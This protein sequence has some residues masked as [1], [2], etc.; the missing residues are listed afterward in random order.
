M[1]T[2]NEFSGSVNG[3]GILVGPNGSQVNIFNSPHGTVA[4]GRLAKT[5][6]DLARNVRRRWQGEE[7]QRGISDPDPLPVQWTTAPGHPSDLLSGSR[8]VPSETDL[9][10]RLDR[11]AKVVRRIGA[12]RRTDAGRLVVLGQAGSGKTILAMQLALRLLD[13]REPADPVPVIFSLGSWDPSAPSLRDWLTSQLERD[14][15]ALAEALASG[16]T[17]ACGL[18]SDRWILPVLD[19][20]DEIACGLRGR[21]LKAVSAIQI[22][23]VLTSRPDEYDAATEG[24]GLSKAVTVQ[25]A[26]LTV[27]ELREY[28]PQTTSR[29]VRRPDGTAVN[30]WDFILGD[31]ARDPCRHACASLAEV[32]RT[33]LMVTLARTVYS[34]ASGPDPEGLLDGRYGSAVELEEHL[35][36]SFISSIYPDEPDDGPGG[37]RWPWHRHWSADRA[38]RWLGYLAA[39]MQQRDTRDLAWWELGTSMGRLPRTLWIAFLA[40]LAFGLATAM[41]NLPVDLVATS[42]G[43]AF[44]IARGIAVGALHGLVVG[45]A[46]GLLYWF[47]QRGEVLKPSPVRIRIFSGGPGR[48]Q[49]RPAGRVKIGIVVGLPVALLIALIDRYLVTWLG[50][51]DGLGGGPLSSLL[52]FVPEAGLAAG[53]VFALISLIE[54]PIDIG[55]AVSPSVLLRSSRA[56]AIFYLLGWALVL[57]PEFGLVTGVTHGALRGLEVGLVYGLEGAFGAGLGYGMVMCAWGQWVALARIWLPLTGRLPWAVVAFLEDACRRGALR[58]AGAVYQFRHARLQDYLAP[59]LRGEPAVAGARPLPYG[60]QQEEIGLLEES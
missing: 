60:H 30:M 47:A 52:G 46:F 49:A 15:P 34:E 53:L 45:L 26:D 16:E 40:A 23:L 31:L 32:L 24:R 58:Q 18:V 48:T 9:H 5:A 10:D 56:N 57:G 4:E 35:L 33:P 6:E 22:P 27:A 2:P 29:L 59:P 39:H 13:I 38:E 11:L 7:E 20:F 51:N 41:G 43:V 19:G 42:H 50:L 14:I 1:S 21:A 44:A 55:T 37:P 54:A 8:E 36:A 25:L 12:R 28:L 3:Q 17:V